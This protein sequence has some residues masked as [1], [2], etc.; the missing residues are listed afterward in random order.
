MKLG[1][2]YVLLVPPALVL[3]LASLALVGLLLSQLPP[4]VSWV[5]GVMV[6]LGVAW[7][8]VRRRG[9]SSFVAGSESSLMGRQS[10]KDGLL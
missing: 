2:L 5:A 6:V 7:L 1:L 4:V 3:S 8:I 10:S 9:S